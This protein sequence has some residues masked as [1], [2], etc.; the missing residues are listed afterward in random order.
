MPPFTAITVAAAD[1]ELA[2]VPDFLR[3][4]LTAPRDAPAGD[5]LPGSL[6]GIAFR[7]GH[8]TLYP[9]PVEG[10]DRESVAV[11]IRVAGIVTV[12]LNEATVSSRRVELS[13]W[14]VRWTRRGDGTV[15]IRERGAVQDAI[16][17]LGGW[18][19]WEMTAAWLTRD[20]RG[21][22][23]DDGGLVWAPAEVNDTTVIQ[24]ITEALATAGSDQLVAAYRTRFRPGQ[25][26]IVTV[27]RIDP[28]APDDEYA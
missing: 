20:D 12:C 1:D 4:Y 23:T 3:A 14:Q 13:R 7:E 19:E 16:G 9:W 8:A 10:D 21:R 5:G 11:A 22:P 25:D 28:P 15:G 24:A 26:A 6:A 17:R 2:R 18:F 27:T